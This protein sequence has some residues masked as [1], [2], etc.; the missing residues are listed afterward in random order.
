MKIETLEDGAT[1][2]CRSC[3]QAVLIRGE[4]DVENSSLWR[5]TMKEDIPEIRINSLQG[6]N[7]G[8]ATPAKAIFHSGYLDEAAPRRWTWI[9]C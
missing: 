1:S 7:L 4:L 2:E 6:E 8:K 9:F 5:Y 3:D